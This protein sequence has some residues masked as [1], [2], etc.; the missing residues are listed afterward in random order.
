VKQQ[1][2]A[3]ITQN[4]LA[5]KRKYFPRKF[6]ASQHDLDDLLIEIK[7]AED[8]RKPIR[9]RGQK[10][11]AELKFIDET[12]K[13]LDLFG[14]KIFARIWIKG[15]GKPF[16]GRSVYTTTIDHMFRT[17][18]LYAFSNNATGIAIADFR[19]PSLNSTISHTIL[20]RKMKATG[21]EFPHV[22]EVPVFGHSENHAILQIADTVCSAILYPIS[23][24]VFCKGHVKNG[25]VHARDA[26]FKTRY[27]KRVKNLQFF[28]LIS[29]SKHGSISVHDGIEVPKRTAR[30]L[31]G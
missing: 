30:H 26:F 13:L 7:G 2:I 31:F 14:V 16:V 19:N 8:L 6:S 17:F 5:L 29:G 28:S 25:H 27:S 24:N 15:I 23:M 21:D 9:N 12:L 4:F 22:L 10:A 3:K 1:D 20:T 18:N 11:A